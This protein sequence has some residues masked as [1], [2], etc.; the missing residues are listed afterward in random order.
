QQH[1][2]RPVT[3]PFR[4]IGTARGTV[5]ALALAACSSETAPTG[6]IPSDGTIKGV[7]TATS[8]FPAPPRVSGTAAPA[9]AGVMPPAPPAIATVTR[10][11]LL[12]LDETAYARAAPTGASGPGAAAQRV[13]PNDTFYAFQSWHYGLIDL[14]RAWA[15]TTG[16]P[17]VLVALVDDG[18]RFD[19]PALAGNLTTD[20]YDFV[21]AADTLRLCAG[22]KI[23]NDAD[24]ST[25]YD[26]NPTIPASYS[27]DSTGTCFVFDTLGGHGVH[28]AG[29]MGAVGHDR[30]GVPG[31][32]WKLKSVPRR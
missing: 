2:D 8:V 17:S 21:S 3:F 24:D 20:G 12:W 16:S 22:G 18:T 13:V 11:R 25:G 30:I 7:I 31:V 27:P 9:T 29:T 5:L 10:N 32:K 15:I 6:W 23:T 28:V 1:Q 26:P 14:P 4:S 19:H